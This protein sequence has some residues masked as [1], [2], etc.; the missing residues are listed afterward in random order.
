M[1]QCADCRSVNRP[2]TT[3]RARGATRG[4][5]RTIKEHGAIGG[6]L[7]QS[8]LDWAYAKRALGR[9]DDPEEVIRRIADYRAQDKYDPLYYA[10]HTVMK[11]QQVAE[12]ESASAGL[13]QTERSPQAGRIPD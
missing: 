11:A 4:Q 8:E 6:T 1:R 13:P 5:G 9:G 10:R 3:F 7:S 2:S 12:R